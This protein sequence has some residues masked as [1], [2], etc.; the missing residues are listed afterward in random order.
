[1]LKFILLLTIV[2]VI[3]DGE[4]CITIML[5]N[6]HRV[7]DHIVIF[8]NINLSDIYV[9][10]VLLSSICLDVSTTPHRNMASKYAACLF[11]M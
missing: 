5:R 7:F 3:W 11:Y 6:K 2:T 9:R 1:M 8:E 10:H 4:F